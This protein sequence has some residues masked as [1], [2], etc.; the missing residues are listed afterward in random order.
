LNNNYAFFEGKIVPIE[1]AKI[2][3]M[4]HA[5]NYGTGAFGGLRGYWN[6]SAEELYVFR[7]LEHF[8]RLLF[9]AK[10]LL[11]D[12]PYTAEDL[13]NLLLTLLQTEGYRQDC[14]VRPLVYKSQPLIGVRLNDLQGDMAMFAIPFGRY[15]NAEEGARV[16]VS[17]WRRVSDTSVPARGKFTGS[18][19]NSAFIKTEAL[20]N[21][22]DEAI[23]LDES[24]HISEGSAENVF[25]VRN[26]KVVTPPINGDILEGITRRTVIQLLQEELGVEVEERPIDRTEFYVCD[27]AFFSGTGVQIAAITEADRRLV[28]DGKMGPLVRE[29]R[30]LYFGIVRGQNPKYMDWLQPV[31]ASQSQPV[32]NR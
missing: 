32:T 7:P 23:V 22:Y 6:D 25:I 18:Y 2:S 9:S 1:E 28:G 10:M 26:G 27:E 20:L 30:D 5:L 8:E 4:T 3:I 16:A 17:S 14:Y 13:N 19:I 31:Y 29:L 15:V 24:G 21:G 12:L 11:I